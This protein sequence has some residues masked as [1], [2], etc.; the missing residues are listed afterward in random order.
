MS[1]DSPKISDDF[2]GAMLLMEDCPN[3]VIISLHMSRSCN[4][5]GLREHSRL[6]QVECAEKLNVGFGSLDSFPRKVK[7]VFEK[8]KISSS[9]YE[10]SQLD[11][12]CLSYTNQGN[13]SYVSLARDLS[14]SITL[15]VIP[16]LTLTLI[17]S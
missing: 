9:S 4:V 17:S 14:L 13:D 15:T 7:N 10:E 8:L 5:I 12:A 11:N 1:M 6:S 16:S 2:I 3:D